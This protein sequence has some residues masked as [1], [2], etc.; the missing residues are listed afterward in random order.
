M[1]ASSAERRRIVVAHGARRHDVSISSEVELGATLQ[2]LGLALQPQAVVVFGLDGQPIDLSVPPNGALE[3]GALITVVE[4]APA[5]AGGGASARAAAHGRSLVGPA[6]LREFAWLAAASAAV[7]TIGSAVLDLATLDLATSADRAGLSGGRAVLAG[8][9]AAVSLVAAL[10][11]TRGAAGR[12][13]PV[14]LAVPAMLAFAAGFSAVPPGIAS[15]FHLAVVCG[16]LAASVAAAIVHARSVGDYPVG[17]TGV[18]LVI[19]VSLSALW[20]LTLLAGWPSYVAA[21]LAAGA[22][23]VGLRIL[24]GTCLAVPPG[25][26]LEFDR[27]SSNASAVRAP[28]PVGSEQVRTHAVSGMI[29][30]ATAQLATGTVLLAAV[31]VAMLPI[32]FLTAPRDALVTSGAIVVALLVTC[33]LALSPRAA[34]T[35][36]T[37]WAPRAAAAVVLAELALLGTRSF[38]GAA[39]LLSPAILVVVA[40][41]VASVSVPLAR[42]TRSL[43]LSRLGDGI[44]TVAIVFALPAAVVAAN[45]VTILRG[46]T[47]T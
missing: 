42:G 13:S 7:I 22:A 21:A 30:N 46:V 3:D 23:P 35:A 26:L 37:R 20:G 34:N 33:A 1:S 24:P 18:V 45:L 25:Q 6:G 14:A 19:L 9:F 44:E 43:S 2:Q 41:V 36:V 39:A 11:A 5:S 10:S 8:I 16:L 4:L 32:V 28:A 17:A 47:S 29:G 12:V 40:L 38:G 27:L 15:A 31:P